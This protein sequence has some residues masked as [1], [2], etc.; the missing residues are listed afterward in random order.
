MGEC[1]PPLWMFNVYNPYYYKYLQRKLRRKKKVGKGIQVLFLLT[2]DMQ[3]AYSLKPLK[4]T[5][6]LTTIFNI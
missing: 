6:Q 4:K 1:S 2:V 5:L 3:H